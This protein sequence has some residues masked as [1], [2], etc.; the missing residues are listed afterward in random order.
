MDKKNHGSHFSLRPGDAGGVTV[1]VKASGGTQRHKLPEVM[2]FETTDGFVP[3]FFEVVG[4][5]VPCKGD[6]YVSGAVPMAYLAGVDF[7]L[8]TGVRIIVKALAKARQVK[9]WVRA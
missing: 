2:W 5:W 7:R 8:E 6:H 4:H 9:I 3:N 1:T